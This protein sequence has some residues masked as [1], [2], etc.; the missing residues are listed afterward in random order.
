MLKVL[1]GFK[2][3]TAELARGAES[4]KRTQPSRFYLRKDTPTSYRDDVGLLVTVRDFL[5]GKDQ[6]GPYVAR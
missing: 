5:R 4:I 3:A 2:M 1:D 6:C